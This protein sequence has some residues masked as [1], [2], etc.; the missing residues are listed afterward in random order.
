M[1]DLGINAF[2]KHT[3]V[4]K[5]LSVYT[6][7]ILQAPTSKDSQGKHMDFAVKLTPFARYKF[8]NSRFSTG[9]YTE[10]KWYAGVT[11]S[12]TFK[13]WALPYVSYQINPSLSAMIQYEMEGHHYLNKP[14]FDFMSY[15][16]DLQAGVSWNISSKVNLSPY[17]QFFSAKNISVD[18]TAISATLSATVL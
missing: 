10:E 15:Q 1:G 14:T 3:I 13:L 9:V 4:T 16:Q 12:K 6:N 18:T 8:T 2:N 11:K 5:N 7:V 17:I